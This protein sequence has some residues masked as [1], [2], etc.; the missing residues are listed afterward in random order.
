ML[1]DKKNV[2]FFLGFE[3]PSWKGRWVNKILL[4]NSK[5]VEVIFSTLLKTGRTAIFQYYPRL[6]EMLSTRGGRSCCSRPRVMLPAAASS[7]TLGRKSI[8]HYCFSWEIGCFFKGH[9]IILL[10]RWRFEITI[11]TMKGKGPCLPLIKMVEQA[12][13]LHFFASPYI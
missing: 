1:F 12:L 4:A 11:E 6:L 8:S 3:H 2:Q 13:C 5:I 9:L 10:H 7:I